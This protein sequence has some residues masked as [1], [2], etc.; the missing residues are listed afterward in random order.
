MTVFE[1]LKSCKTVDEMM[2]VLYHSRLNKG[3]KWLTRLLES[4][5]VEK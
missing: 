2:T 4:E 5:W 3:M 1:K